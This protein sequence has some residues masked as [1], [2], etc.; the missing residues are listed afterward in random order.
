MII[1]NKLKKK[2]NASVVRINAESIELN[3][4]IPYL[5]D[6]PE[7]GQ[8]TGF[9]I[10]SKH[11]LTCSH[12]VNNS[13]NIYIDIPG[14]T[15]SKYHAEVIYI[16]PNFD[17]AVLRI[18]NYTSKY[19]LKLG[20]S[21]KLIEGANVFV[22]G[23]PVSNSHKMNNPENNLKY[24][25]G[26]I[27][28]QQSG[29]IQTDSAINPGNS[30]GPLFYK[31]SVIGIN[32]QKLVRSDVENVGY[33][34]PI[35]NFKVLHKI[36]ENKKENKEQILYQSALNAEFDNTEKEM[37]KIM[38]NGKYDNGIIIS[39]IYP[40]S[41]LEKSNIKKDAILLKINNLSINNYG[42]INKRWIGTQLDI[43][44]YVGSL[45][46]DS[47]IDLV[48]YYKGKVNKTKIKLLPNIKPIREL[49]HLFEKVD[50]HILAGI[51]FMNLSFNH[52]SEENYE[53][54]FYCQKTINQMKPKL[55]ISFIFPN[56]RANIINNLKKNDFIKEINDIEVNS[57]DELKKAL[58]KPII[59]NKKKYIKIVNENNRSIIMSVDDVKEE[60]EKFSK[61]YKYKV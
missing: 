23:Y 2:I 53:L 43:N 1:D 24:T 7:K 8:G 5:L 19:F 31:D 36:K 56:T 55:F 15:N 61:L 10:D 29:F 33:A 34:V 11:I 50:Y 13:K 32:S 39:S 46:T 52:I 25:N 14:I 51:I 54:Y 47:F 4:Q 18:L 59:I 49:Y 22:V 38:T 42:L 17:I 27:S 57:V 28:G 6:N 58:Q 35:N 3:W 9:F 45:K 41:I 30:G 44:T 48:Y 40:T 16:C 12:V 21:D 26:I 37:V 60:D 20:D